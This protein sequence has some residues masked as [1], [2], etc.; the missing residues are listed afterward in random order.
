MCIMRIPF[1]LKPS[2][3]NKDIKQYLISA[4]Q[5]VYG[6]TEVEASR[7]KSNGV[8]AGESLDAG[9]ETDGAR[10]AVWHR[11]HSHKSSGMALQ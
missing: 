10:G 4:P 11:G 3:L 5:N 8:R 9:A 2:K 7:W 1:G 6:V